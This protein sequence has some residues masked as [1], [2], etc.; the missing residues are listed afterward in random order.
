MMRL[1]GHV[2]RIGRQG[3]HSGLQRETSWKVSFRK[4]KRWKVNIKIYIR[5]KVRRIEVRSDRFRIVS[6]NWPSC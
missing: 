5:E 4:T 1:A 3:M 6:K 2:V